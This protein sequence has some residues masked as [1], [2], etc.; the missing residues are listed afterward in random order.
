V[1][2]SI[3]LF[4]AIFPETL[5]RIADLLGVGYNPAL[6]VGVA[7]LVVFAVQITQG[8]VISSLSL[9]SRDLAQKVAQLEWQIRQLRNHAQ[10]LGEQQNG[11][12]SAWV[13]TVR[14][15]LTLAEE[16]EEEIAI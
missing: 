5:D 1:I 7:F 16:S 12:A 8:V 11:Q 10:M 3:I 9:R 13:T 14:E 2:S 15:M 4:L 6:L